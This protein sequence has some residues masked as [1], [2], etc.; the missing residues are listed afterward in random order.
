M[1]EEESPRFHN[2]DT[3][4]WAF[5][6]PRPEPEFVTSTISGPRTVRASHFE[7]GAIFRGEFSPLIV[8][9]HASRGWIE[10]VRTGKLSGTGQLFGLLFWRVQPILYGQRP[11]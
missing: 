8:W 6:S 5:G 4:V 1:G 2:R 9:G 7:V 10:A 11:V 3:L